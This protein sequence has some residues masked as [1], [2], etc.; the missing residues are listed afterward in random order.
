M[1]EKIKQ[2]ASFFNNKKRIDGKDEIVFF[3]RN[4][5][6]VLSSTVLA[7]IK[8]LQLKAKYLVT[9]TLLGEYSSS[10]K[11]RGMEFEKLRV[12]V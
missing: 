4:E 9:D 8:R 11:G 5:K 12:H 1:L 7:K 2:L 6:D 3:D 10:F